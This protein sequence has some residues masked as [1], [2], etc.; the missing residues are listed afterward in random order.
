MKKNKDNMSYKHK[1]KYG[2]NFLNNQEDILDKIIEVSKITKEDEI[3]E[4]GAGQGALTEKLLD[5][6]K[7]LTCVE[8][9]KDLEGFLRKKFAKKTN[10]NLVIE[11]ILEFDIDRYISANTKVVANIP[12]YITSPIINKLIENRKKISS[13]FLMVQKEVGERICATFGKE[14]SV[15]TLV[16]EY[17]GKAE[18]L[19]TIDRKY[20]NPIPN[21]D[22]AF[23]GIEFYKNRKYES[24]IDEELFFRYVKIAFLNKRKN[25]VNN[26]VALNYS[27]DDIKKVLKDLDISEK[28][29]AENIKIEDF[30]KLIK[31]FENLK[32]R[33][34]N[35]K[36]L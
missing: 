22:S 29:R 26:L 30:I 16:V 12:Y 19:F 9:D 18:Y 35:E 3:L 14:R 28:E 17:Y 2:Q 31:Y 5:I 1:K 13:V 11:D 25:I 20:F 10:F 7:K 27:K 24:Q 15:L 6:S 8:I 21:V 23:I 34:M 33:E 36:E 32:E 4:I